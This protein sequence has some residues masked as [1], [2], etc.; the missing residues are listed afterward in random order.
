VTSFRIM[1]DTGYR[2]GTARVLFG[3]E[4]EEG[5]MTKAVCSRFADIAGD[6]WMQPGRFPNV[7]EA[8]V[9]TGDLP[10]QC[11]YVIGGSAFPC[12]GGVEAWEWIRV[13][14]PSLL[15]SPYLEP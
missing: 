14:R 15:V 7:R 6:M 13:I 3:Y 11:I 1:L 2:V 5:P 8:M 10:D 12:E 9:V 4:K